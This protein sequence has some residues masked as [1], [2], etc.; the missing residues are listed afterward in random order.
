[1]HNRR[2]GALALLAAHGGGLLITAQ[3]WLEATGHGDTS[4]AGYLAVALGAFGLG[5]LS[6]YVALRHSGDQAHQTTKGQFLFRAGE[7]AS[8]VVLVALLTQI[9]IQGGMVQRE[10]RYSPWDS[11]PSKSAPKEIGTAP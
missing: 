9:A 6:G 3:Q 4:R 1:M 10:T 11:A 8:L 2:E 5:A 7:A